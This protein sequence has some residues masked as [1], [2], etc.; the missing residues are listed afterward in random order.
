[1]AELVGRFEAFLQ[2][3]AEAQK[4]DRAALAQHP[5]AA[6]LEHF[7]ALRQSEAGALAARIAY[8]R[9]PVV[10][11][12]RRRHHVHQL[13]LVG[14]RHQH[15]AGQAAEIGQIER[16]GMGRAVGAHEAGA[17]ED[18]AYGQALDS[19]VMH[20]LV[21]GPLQEGR[22][23]RRKRLEALR[24]QTRREGHP[25]L[26]GDAD[27]E[28]ALREALGEFVEPRPRRHRRGQRDDALVIGFRLGNQRLAANTAV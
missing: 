5:A 24:R 11:R 4:R 19:H 1:M 7:A 28:A 22:I 15:E 3:R 17:V 25:M 26:L 9:R 12:R 14:R 27:I 21:I 6:D 20:D 18:E 2:P 16:A 8:C 13:D 23:D 10:D